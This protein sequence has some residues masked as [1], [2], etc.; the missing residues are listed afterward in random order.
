MYNNDQSAIYLQLKANFFNTFVTNS[1]AL[2]IIGHVQVKNGQAKL[3]YFVFVNFCSNKL[4]ENNQKGKI[5]SCKYE[6]YWFS[7]C[8]LNF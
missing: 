4:R 3:G 1:Q 5:L 2:V 6:E 7:I 8:R